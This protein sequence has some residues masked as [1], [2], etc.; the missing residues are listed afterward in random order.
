MGVCLGVGGWGVGVSHCV[1]ARV[2]ACVCTCDEF[3]ILH[4]NSLPRLMIIIIIIIIINVTILH[5]KHITHTD[6]FPINWHPAGIIYM[7]N[8]CSYIERYL[9]TLYHH[10]ILK[11]IKHYYYKYT[12]DWWKN[13]K[14]VSGVLCDRKMNV[15]IKGRCTEHW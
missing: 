5:F 14:R 12:K 10:T 7:S 8:A 2:R 6:D 9:S 1:R 4:N 11:P 15:K 3:E 13:W